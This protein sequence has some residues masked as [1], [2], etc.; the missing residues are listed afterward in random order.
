MSGQGIRLGWLPTANGCVNQAATC[1]G[2]CIPLQQVMN[3]WQ[4]VRS[5]RAACNSSSSKVSWSA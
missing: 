3:L 1:G 4:N 5:R 2:L